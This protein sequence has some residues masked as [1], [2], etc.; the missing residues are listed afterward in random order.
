MSEAVRADNVIP[1]AEMNRLLWHSRRGMLELDALLLP[2][3]R[4]VYPTL[5]AE[6]RVIYGELLDCLDSNLF[7]WFM[8]KEVPEARFAGIIAKILERARQFPPTHD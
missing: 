3:T 4:K 6:E 2:F 7:S 8:D 1:Q 5:S